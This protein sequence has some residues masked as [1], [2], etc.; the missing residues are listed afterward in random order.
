[1]P[2]SEALFVTV[3]GLSH[4]DFRNTVS[5]LLTVPTAFSIDALHSLVLRK[6]AWS[7]RTASGTGKRV[8]LFFLFMF[9]IFVCGDVRG[10]VVVVCVVV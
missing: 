9:P 1:M 3:V 10:G 6:V 8:C 5:T 4:G 7:S 2:I